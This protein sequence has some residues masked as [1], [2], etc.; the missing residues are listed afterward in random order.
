ML[1]TG[2]GDDITIETILNLL[3]TVNRSEEAAKT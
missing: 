3:N 2:I 1:N